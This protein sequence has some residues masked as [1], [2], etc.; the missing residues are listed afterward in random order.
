MIFPWIEVE[1][2][3][4]LR[5]S[6]SGSTHHVTAL[7]FLKYMLNL[8]HVILQDAATMIVLHPERCAHP[9]FSCHKVFKEAQFM[10][11]FFCLF[12]IILFYN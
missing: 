9:I 12:Y 3:K 2:G 6:E 1:L 11:S 4:V 8:R 7:C 5:N 10:V